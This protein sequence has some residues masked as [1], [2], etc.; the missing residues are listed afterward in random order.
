MPMNLLRPPAGSLF[1]RLADA[2]QVLRP[3]GFLLDG[4][5]HLTHLTAVR[6]AQSAG[7][8]PLQ[9]TQAALPTEELALFV[10]RSRELLAATDEPI[11]QRLENEV[12][13]L[14]VPLQAAGLFEILYIAHPVLAAMVND[15][16]AES[17]SVL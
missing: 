3:R 2:C 16:L 9:S 8:A 15:H 13:N 12:L 5:A 7:I 4:P 6:P 1:Q 17:A 11:R 10:T 14:A